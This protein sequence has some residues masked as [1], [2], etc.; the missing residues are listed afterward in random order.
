MD[1]SHDRS[2]TLKDIAQSCGVSLT[3]VSYALRNHPCVQLK[4]AKRIRAVASRL[5]YDP[6]ANTAARKMVLRRHGREV[7]NHVVG[8]FI[9]P[10]FHTTA[11]YARL[12]EGIMEV[13]TK[14]GYAILIT[15]DYG[16]HDPQR[17]RIP[18]AFLAGNIDGLITF[19]RNDPSF[20]NT[21]RGSAGFGARPVVSL[22]QSQHECAGV[23]A[24]FSAGAEAAAAYLLDL[25]HRRFLFLRWIYEA[26]PR[27]FES[28]FLKWEGVCRAFSDRGLKVE[29]HVQV[30]QIRSYH[31]LDPRMLHD[32]NAE[33][34]TTVEI[35]RRCVRLASYLREHP[36]IT[37]VLA[38]NDASALRA[39]ALLE[40]E[41]IRV[42]RDVSIVGFDD[43]D[44]KLDAAGKNLLTTVR[45]PLEEL[46]REAA[47]QLVGAI[48]GRAKMVE[49]VILPTERVV[50]GSTAVPGRR[51]NV[52]VGSL[53][54]NA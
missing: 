7:L 35:D 8:L 51:G 30:A 10:A 49:P 32:L 54:K 31:W 18:P 39:W 12:F 16:P 17:T 6:A 43:T 9:P 47:R 21:L 11:Y 52:R 42:P 27:G 44:P 45:L 36:E 2:H 34:L 1:D 37:A 38:M 53:N 46:G 50:R 24:D 33:L 40:R 41:G 13:L 23:M 29:R 25:G 4:T 15:Y 14:E 28:E 3:T 20:L 19:P 48:T 22:L 26:P 5:K